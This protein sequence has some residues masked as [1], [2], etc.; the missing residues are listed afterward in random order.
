MKRIILIILI[1]LMIVPAVNAGQK[2]DWEISIFGINP[3]DFEGRK[4]L[5]IIV[6]VLTSYGVHELG[7]Y[8]MANIVGMNPSLRWDKGPVV[9][10]GGAEYDNA[11]DREKLW[12]HSGGFLAQIIVGSMLTIAEDT[13]HSD[14]AFGFNSSTMVIASVYT[15][16]GG[17]NYETSDIQNINKYGNGNGNAAGIGTAVY[18][19]MLSYVNLNK[20]NDW[21][22]LP[23][24]LRFEWKPSYR[25]NGFNY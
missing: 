22:R 11:S 20:D 17:K 3:K 18:S 6:G 21:K 7:H 14:F 15:I 12:F 10:A 1:V 24:E 2:S 25:D 8:M 9:W 23:P 16:T 13:R 4:P 19:G 5:P